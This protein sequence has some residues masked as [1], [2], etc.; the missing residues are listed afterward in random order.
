M[1]RD[2]LLKLRKCA[3]TQNVADALTKS[4]PAPS[5]VKHREYLFGSWVPFEAFYVS[6]GE[7]AASKAG[8][9]WSV[10]QCSRAA[11]AA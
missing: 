11:P 2:K 7:R 1:V 6:I 5:F 3:G 9:R 10:L 4:L 8:T